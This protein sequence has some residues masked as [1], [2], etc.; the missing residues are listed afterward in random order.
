MAAGVAAAGVWQPRTCGSC[1]RGLWH[2]P[3]LGDQ[4]EEIGLGIAGGIERDD[5][6]LKPVSTVLSQTRGASGGRITL[7]MFAGTV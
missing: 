2:G 3:A 6:A 7:V 5:C 4:A 1:L